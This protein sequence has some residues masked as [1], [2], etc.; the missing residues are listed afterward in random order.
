MTPGDVR[1][2][3]AVLSRSGRFLLGTI[4]RSISS[5]SPL[6]SALPGALCLDRSP[7]GPVGEAFGIPS[8]SLTTLPFFTEEGSAFS[9][10]VLAVSPTD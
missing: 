1:A 9:E 5:S 2:C 3:I 6:L 10:S 4:A 7:F 8:T